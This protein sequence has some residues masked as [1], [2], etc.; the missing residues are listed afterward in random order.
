MSA[1]GDLPAASWFRKW[2]V[3]SSHVRLRA[4]RR[5]VWAL[6]QIVLLAKLDGGRRPIGFSLAVIRLWM[7]AR[8]VEVREWQESHEPELFYGSAGRS[9]VR[10]AWQSAFAAEKAAL[11]EDEFA[12][13]LL[14]LLKAF[15]TVPHDLPRPGPAAI[16]LVFRDWRWRSNG[17]QE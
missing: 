9:A 8:A 10:A 11:R 4:S 15:E 17:C 7:R 13:A 1:A 12:A 16:R 3:V 2:A 6:V 14:D 5:S